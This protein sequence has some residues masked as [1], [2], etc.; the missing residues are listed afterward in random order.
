[1]LNKLRVAMAVLLCLSFAVM[2]ALADDLTQTEPVVQQSEPVEV[3]QPPVLARDY[4]AD[5][6]WNYPQYVQFLSNGNIL[7]SRVGSWDPGI[8]EVDRSG[9]EVWYFRGIQ[10]TVP[11]DWIMEIPWWQIQGL[12]GHP[13]YLGWWN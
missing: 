4:I 5:I 13:M 9:R 11:G 2:P 12:P 10:P 8:I 3:E 6:N 7:Q 1:M